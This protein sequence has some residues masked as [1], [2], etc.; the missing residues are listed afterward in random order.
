VVWRQ[1]PINTEQRPTVRCGARVG[2][3]VWWEEKGM[4]GGF[5]GIEQRARP[6][7]LELDDGL[8]GDD[9]LEGGGVA[10]VDRRVA[11]EMGLVE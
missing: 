1:L 5:C 4:E 6:C 10:R 8:G 11:Q 7:V 2:H 9:G 3:N